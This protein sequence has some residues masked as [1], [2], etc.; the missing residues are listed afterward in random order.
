MKPPA[1]KLHRY[2]V[3]CGGGAGAGLTEPRRYRS[4]HWISETSGATDPARLRARQCTAARGYGL[5]VVQL[6]L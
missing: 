4:R 3:R 2:V 1:A 6:P 5:R